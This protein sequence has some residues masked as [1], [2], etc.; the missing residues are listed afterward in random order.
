MKTFLKLLSSLFL[1]SLSFGQTVLPPDDAVRQLLVDR[2]DRDHRGVGIVVGLIDAKGRRI[3]SYG[4]PA[5]GDKRAL[6]GDTVFEIGSITKVFTSLVLMDMAQKG[7]IALDDPVSKFLPSTAKV[8]EYNGKKITL[9]DLSTQSSGLPRMPSNFAPKDPLNPYADYTVE[10]MYDFL[11]HYELTREIGSKYEYSNLG[12]GLLGHA[13]SLKAGTGYEAMVKARVLA[14]LKMTDTAVTLN[15][16][17]QARIAT[18]HNDQ[19]NPTPLWD[20]PT[21]AG[22]GALRSTANDMLTFLAAN[23]GYT[24]SSLAKAI[25]AEISIRKPTGNPALE[26]AYAWHILKKGDRSLIWHNGG[27]GGFRTFIGFDPQTKVGMVLLS[28]VSTPEGVDDIGRHIWDASIP[29]AQFDTKERKVVPVETPVLES[30]VGKYQLAP[31]FVLTVG[32]DG[33]RMF[34]QATGQGPFEIFPESDTEFFAKVTNLQITFGKDELVLHQGGQDTRA[35]RMEAAK[36]RKEVVLD[37]KTL[38]GYAGRYQLA[39][40]FILTVTNEGGHL[41]AQATGQ[42]KAEIFAESKT[43]FFLKVVDAQF[44]FQLGADGKATGVVLHQNG[45]DVPGKRVE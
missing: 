18:G 6:D 29:L 15:T 4:R 41:M 31:G 21:F 7:E 20:L 24:E 13:L 35:K 45:A 8:P 23:L 37:P 27:T 12:V 2:I 36:D 42:S 14:P 1:V 17:M 39:P 26:I 16:G 38:D 25:A 30:Y 3:I 11:G 19:L 40:N 34:A 10:R 44:T 5:K 22:A 28:N 43:D 9:A 33:A 32:R